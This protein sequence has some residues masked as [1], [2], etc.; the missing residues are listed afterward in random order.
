M[1]EPHHGGASKTTD[2]AAGSSSATDVSLREYLEG[3]LERVELISR[4][5]MAKIEQRLD[6]IEQRAEERLDTTRRELQA[7][8]AA[9]EQAIDK[10]DAATE[11]RF[12]SVNEFRAQLSDQTATFMPRELVDP[13][14][15]ALEK[16][17][18][19]LLG[20]M[21]FAMVL[22]PAITGFIVYLLTRH[23]VPVK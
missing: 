10:A 19:K 21:A 2:P 15:V 13:R 16:F 14:L 4:E 9:S 23:A 18:A 3:T 1:S 11:K 6:G 22:M 5:R 8:F 20:A 12:E 7:A 17:Q